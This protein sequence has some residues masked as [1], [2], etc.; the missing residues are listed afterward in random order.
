MGEKQ[1]KKLK[2]AREHAKKKVHTKGEAKKKFMQKVRPYEVFYPQRN[3]C[4]SNGCKKQ[5][6]AS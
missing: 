5:I 2:H 1:N 6:S 3:S 4:T